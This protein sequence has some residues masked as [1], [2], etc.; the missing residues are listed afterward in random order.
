M[1]LAT[2][3]SAA[4][5][6]RGTINAG[7]LV[8]NDRRYWREQHLRRHHQ[9]RRDQRQRDWFWQRHRY[10]F[11]TITGGIDNSGTIAVSVSATSLANGTRLWH[12]YRGVSLSNGLTNT[13]LISVNLLRAASSL[14]PSPPVSGPRVAHLVSGGV[15][16]SGTIAVV[17]LGVRAV[18]IAVGKATLQANGGGTVSGGI[19]N[20]GMITAS[21]KKESASR[22]PVAPPCRGGITNTGTIMGSTSAI[23]V[24]GEGG[25]TTITQSAGALIGSVVGSGNANADV[26][27]FTGGRIVRFRRRKAIWSRASAPTTRRAARSVPSSRVTPSTAVVARDPVQRPDERGGGEARRRSRWYRKET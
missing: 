24:S 13:G 17:A 26:L 16:N 4:S 6:I 19:T 27:N 3:S 15:S 23:D 7:H 10:H 25:P 8:F 21:G 18:G 14:R 20:S 1:S 5:A 22:L 2:L 11:S 9:F 12:C